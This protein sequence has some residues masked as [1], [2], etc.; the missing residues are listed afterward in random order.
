MFSNGTRLGLMSKKKKRKTKRHRNCFCAASLCFVLLWMRKKENRLLASE[1]KDIG[2]IL[3][4]QEKNDYRSMKFLLSPDRAPRIY[5]LY[6]G[7]TDDTPPSAVR[8]LAFA[9][10]PV[11]PV[12]QRLRAAPAVLNAYNK[13]CEPI[14]HEFDIPQV[15]FDILM[16]LNNNPELCTA[17]QISEFRKIKKNLV[18]VHVDKLVTAGYLQRGSVTGDRRK[19]LLSCTEKA[20]PILKAGLEMQQNFNQK[21]TRNIPEEQ[22]HVYKEII[23]SMAANACQMLNE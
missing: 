18:S 17:Q 5:P 21:L 11:P 23:D 22:I 16:F 14:L 12:R 13:M 8:R 4:K 9:D 19:V 3:R 10:T 1:F 6:R 2:K 15:S 20:Q 7:K